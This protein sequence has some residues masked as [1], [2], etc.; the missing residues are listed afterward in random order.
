MMVHYRWDL[1]TKRKIFLKKLKGD[2]QESY[3]NINDYWSG[4]YYHFLIEALQRLSICEDSLENHTLILSERHKKPFIEKALDSFNIKKVIYLNQ[5]NMIYCPNLLLPTFPG[6]PDWHRPQ[7][8]KK[9]HK[10]LTSKNSPEKIP[11]RKIFLSREKAESRRILNR[12]EVMA[13]LKEFQFEIICAENLSFEEQVKTFFETSHLVT[14]HGA[15]LT[16]T[17]FMQPGTH[18]FEIRKD[19]YGPLEDKERPSLYQ[20]TYWQ[21]CNALNINY[22]YL[23]AQA[24]KPNAY[25]RDSDLTLNISELEK[26]KAYFKN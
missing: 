17:I 20:N 26:V 9:I 19:H 4:E 14:P 18:V 10:K 11:H 13:F 23:K 15:G 7:L 21:I 25:Y 8:L 16:N 24:D 5:K 3:I 6:P 2:Q 1:L 22:Y 12:K